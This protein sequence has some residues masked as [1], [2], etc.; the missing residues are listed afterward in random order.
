MVTAA[1]AI[2]WQHAPKRAAALVLDAFQ[3]SA[4]PAKLK[5]DR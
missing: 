4:S 5:A 1:K 3:E 2:G